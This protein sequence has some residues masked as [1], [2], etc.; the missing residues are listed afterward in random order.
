MLKFVAGWGRNGTNKFVRGSLLETGAATSI[1]QQLQVPIVPFK[2][3]KSKLEGTKI[4]DENHICAGAEIGF[5]S[6][7]ILKIILFKRYAENFFF[8]SSYLNSVY[9]IFWR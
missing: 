7:S 8:A 4:S 1:L 5:F 9:E 6:A 2:E 3:C